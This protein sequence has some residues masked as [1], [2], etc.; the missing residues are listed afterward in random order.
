MH[1]GPLIWGGATIKSGWFNTLVFRLI[2]PAV[3][4]FPLMYS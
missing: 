2:L 1:L 4:Y 3:D